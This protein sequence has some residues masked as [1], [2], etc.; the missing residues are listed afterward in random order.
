MQKQTIAILGAGFGGLRA[1]LLLGRRLRRLKLSDRYEATLIDRNHYHTYTPLLYEVTATPQELANHCDL[2]A[3]TTHHIQESIAGLPLVFRQ[4]DVTKI[5]LAG[6]TLYTA[7]DDRIRFDYLILAPGSET[8]YFDIPGLRE[9]SY[10]FKTFLDAVRLRDAIASLRATENRS[11]AVLVGGGGS[12]GVELAAELKGWRPRLEVTVV[13]S[14]PSL[15]PGF[16]P[17]AVRRAE[18]RLRKLG[19]RSR[20]NSCIAAAKP[21]EA[22]LKNGEALPFDVLIWTGGVRPPRSIQS[23]PLKTDQRGRILAGE[24]LECAPGVYAIG[25]IA[26]VAYSDGAP[27]PGVARAAILQA[28]VAAKNIIEDIKAKEGFSLAARRYFFRPRRYPYILPVGGKHA[29]AQIG[30][31]IIA[32]FLGWI[33]KGLVEL[34]YLRSIMP[35]GKALRIW[36]KGL[37]TFTQ[38]DRLG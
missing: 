30:P 11:P 14:A 38:N 32:G 12:A 21:N 36:L 7:A 24:D 34:N 2:K 13:E 33:L 35:F 16:S 3:L 23:L 17:G 26:G 5:D 18:R 29:I 20:T 10:A 4:D 8:H 6:R 31:L 1:A 19:V 25:D 27:V 28:T 37:A 22:T 9:N 15:L